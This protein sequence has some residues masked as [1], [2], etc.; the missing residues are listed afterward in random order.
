[1]KRKRNVVTFNEEDEIKAFQNTLRESKA[2]TRER[3]KETQRN[4]PIYARISHF[5]LNRVWIELPLFP[6]CT[7]SLPVLQAF[8]YRYLLLLPLFSLV[9]GF[10]PLIP[11]L[12]HNNRQ[13]ERR[14]CLRSRATVHSCLSVRRALGRR[15]KSR[16]IS[17]TAGGLVKG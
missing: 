1:M 5:P 7:K 10:F 16:S 13:T 12:P 15:R 4:L 11:L 2:Q 6:N 8:T 17:T 14:S 3:I 9:R